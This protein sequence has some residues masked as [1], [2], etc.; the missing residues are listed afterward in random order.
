MASKI[1][2]TFCEFSTVSQSSKT[3]SSLGL[4]PCRRAMI[5]ERDRVFSILFFQGKQIPHGFDGNKNTSISAVVPFLTHLSEN[6]NHI[7]TDPIQQ[8][9]GSHRRTTREHILQQLPTHDGHAPPLIII[10]LIKPAPVA[11]RNGANLVVIGRH[12]KH[13]TVC[14]AIIADGTNILTI[15][16]RRNAAQRARLLANS[17]VIVVS[18]VIFLPRLQ[19]SLESGNAARKHKHNVLT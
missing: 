4:K 11:D 9:R 1:L 19:A 2:P 7:E 18:K 16:H 13:L 17:N 3:S 5:N 10:P 14:R 15:D 12:T 8:Q 6:A